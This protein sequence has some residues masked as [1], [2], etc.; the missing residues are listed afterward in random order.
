MG[1][2]KAEQFVRLWNEAVEGRHGI[3]W[4]AQKMNCSDQHVHQ[5]A[6]SLRSQG[7]KLPNIRRTFVETIDVAKLNRMIAE[8]FGGRNY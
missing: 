4:I 6:A 3:S 5:L 1:K 7:V 8:Q 2:V